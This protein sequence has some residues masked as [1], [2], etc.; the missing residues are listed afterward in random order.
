[1]QV[2]ENVFKFNIAGQSYTVDQYVKPDRDCN[3]WTAINRGDGVVFINGIPL[4]PSPLGP[5][6]A[7]ETFTVGGNKGEIWGGD[8]NVQFAPG[9]LSP[10]LV[11]IQ[12]FYIP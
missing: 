9:Q 10:N 6:F 7:G 11:L 3:G 4:S 2:Y 5:G 12:K 1:M 8:L